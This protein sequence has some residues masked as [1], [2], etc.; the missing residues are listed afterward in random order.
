MGTQL[1][2]LKVAR[3]EAIER[4]GFA[5]IETAEASVLRQE[6]KR[7]NEKNREPSAFQ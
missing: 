5:H 2:A 3:T 6:E 1:S 7:G 4:G